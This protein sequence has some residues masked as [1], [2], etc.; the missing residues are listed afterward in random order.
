MTLNIDYTLSTNYYQLPIN[1][2][3]NF[4]IIH[5]ARRDTPVYCR[6]VK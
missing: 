4:N 3:I 6:K 1:N 2:Y 5:K